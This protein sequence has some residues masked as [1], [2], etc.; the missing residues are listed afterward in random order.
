MVL[1][2]RKMK[3]N[4][5]FRPLPEDGGDELY[6]NGVF[7]FNITKLVKFIKASPHLFQPEEV[8]IKT[9]R[10]CPSSNLSESTIQTANLADPIILAEIAPDRFNVIDGHHRLERAYRDGESK[11]LAYRVMAEQHVAFLSSVETYKEYI[12]YWNEKIKRY[13]KYSCPPQ[14]LSNTENQHR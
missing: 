14:Q 9:A 10:T 13:D 11:I 7:L 3:V 2:S 1:Q 5:K 8:L 12:Q 6:P 4:K